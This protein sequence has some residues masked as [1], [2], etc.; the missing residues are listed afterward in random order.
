MEIWQKWIPKQDMP[1]VLYNESLVD[2]KNGFILT[3]EDEP[4]KKKLIVTFDGRVLSYR[5]TDEGSLLVMLK[6]LDEHYGV[7]FYGQWSLFEV[8]NSEYIKWFLHQ[9][10]GIYTKEEV[11]HY[12]FLTPFDVIEVLTTKTPG[13]EILEK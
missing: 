13:V 9:S 4:N 11:K 10:S 12:V 7:E 2:D 8:K 1:T 6:F 5:N 3:F